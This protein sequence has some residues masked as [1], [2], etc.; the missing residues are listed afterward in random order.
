[1]IGENIAALVHPVAGESEGERVGEAKGRPRGHSVRTRRGGKQPPFVTPPSEKESGPK[2]EFDDR[3]QFLSAAVDDAPSLA[4][5]LTHARLAR[6]SRIWGKF[7]LAK[8]KRE[9]VQ[10]IFFRHY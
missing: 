6:N 4:H 7:S 9:E 8:R 10:R 3:F 5:S 1:M 2:L